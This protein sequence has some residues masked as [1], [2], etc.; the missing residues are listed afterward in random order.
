MTIKPQKSV[1][2]LLVIG[3]FLLPCSSVADQIVMKNGDIISGQVKKIIDGDLFIEPEY[4]DEF[5]VD[6]AAVD[7]IRSDTLYEI[8]M[9]DGR[10]IVAKFAGGTDSRQILTVESEELYV[11]MSELIEVSEPEQWYDRTSHID[12]NMVWNGGNT[13]SRNN[14]L[15]FDTKL[16]TGNHRQLFEL[17]VRRDE[18]DGNSTKEQDLFRY[19][20]NWI[21]NEP[22]YLGFTAGFERDPVRELDYRHVLGAFIGRDIFN[23]RRKYFTISAGVGYTREEIGEEKDSGPSALWHLRYEHNLKGGDLEFFHNQTLIIQSYGD[24]NTILK[25]NTGF[26]FDLLKDIYANMSLRFDYETDPAPGAEEKDSTFVVGV[27][28]EF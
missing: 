11:G 19:G 20:Y 28:A 26:R 13:E 17:T 23:D 16:K 25:T 22:W 21:F 6:L 14:L 18:T 12:V 9:A 3:S 7:S 8:E 10:E 15:F 1:F 5:A 2:L 4:A 27:G 24:H